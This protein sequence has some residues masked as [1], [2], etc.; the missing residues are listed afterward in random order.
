MELRKR[1]ERQVGILTV[2]KQQHQED[3]QRLRDLRPIDDD[4]MRCLFKDNIP[5]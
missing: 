2:T 4:F 3:L 5:A 1:K